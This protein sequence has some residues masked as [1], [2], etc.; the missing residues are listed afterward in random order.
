LNAACNGSIR[1]ATSSTLRRVIPKRSRV[2]GTPSAKLADRL[3]EAPCFLL[4][5]PAGMRLD[6]IK[7]VGEV[8][9]ATAYVVV[10][11]RRGD[12]DAAPDAMRHFEVHADRIGKGT[13][14]T[15]PG[16]EQADRRQIAGEQQFLAFILF[17]RHIDQARQ[18]LVEQ[19]E[20]FA[21]ERLGPPIDPQSLSIRGVAWSLLEEWA[22]RMPLA[23]AH[24]LRAPAPASDPGMLLRQS[25][26]PQPW[27]IPGRRGSGPPIRWRF[28]RIEACHVVREAD[29]EKA[30]KLR[31]GFSSTWA[32]TIAFSFVRLRSRSKCRRPPI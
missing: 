14:N 5:T 20:C 4:G 6:H 3:R 18:V 2:R 19:S 15:R 7:E 10:D 23:S 21:V 8:V 12:E 31:R 27:A 22:P 9:P 11:H 16:I 17:L 13:G 1:L 25:T 30:S 29:V 28:R 32:T 24:T 26:H